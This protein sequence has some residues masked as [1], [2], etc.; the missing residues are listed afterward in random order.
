VKLLEQIN[1]ARTA[2]GAIVYL[3]IDETVRIRG[4]NYDMDFNLMTKIEKKEQNKF[5]ES[6][7][8]FLPPFETGLHITELGDRHRLLFNKYSIYRNHVLIVTQDF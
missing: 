1:E 5:L 7:N 4:D 3:N 2:S 6:K 8:P